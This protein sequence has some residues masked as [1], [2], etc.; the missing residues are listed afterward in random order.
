M[1]KKPSI[2]DE[3]TAAV[4]SIPR[5]PRHEAS[6][7]EAPRTAIEFAPPSLREE[8]LENGAALTELPAE[9]IK[10]VEQGLVALQQSHADRD[11]LRRQNA[12]LKVRIAELETQLATRQR[13]EH[14]IEKRVH[15]CL[16]ERDHAVSKT[17]ELHGVLSSLA[18]ILIGYYNPQNHQNGAPVE[19]IKTEEKDQP[20]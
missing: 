7:F 6:E 5:L 17:G 9:R 12:S 8:A 16:V 19:P 4:K 11:W 10:L 18:A 13:E 14:I 20:A 2:E 1:A 3:I 15:D